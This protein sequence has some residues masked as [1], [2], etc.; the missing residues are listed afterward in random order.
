M[1]RCIRVTYCGAPGYVGG[2]TGLVRKRAA[3]NPEAIHLLK[4][5]DKRKEKKRKTSGSS[6]Q[7]VEILTYM[8]H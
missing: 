4:N 2:G 1:A 7:I 6:E 3:Q 5:N 8:W